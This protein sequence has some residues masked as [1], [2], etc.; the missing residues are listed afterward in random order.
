[1][2]QITL[3]NLKLFFRDKMTVFF[4]LLGVLIIIG[5]YV[6][7]LGDTIT[8]GMQDIPNARF[9]MDSWIMAGVLAVTSITTTMGAF[10]IMVDDRH[11]KLIKDFSASP[12]SRAS[13]AGGY[14]LSAYIIGVLISII[15]L[16]LFQFYVVSQG[17]HFL[18]PLVLIKVLG[19]VLL[20][21]LASSSMMFF[22]TSLIKS[23]NAFG[24]ASTVI[25]TLIGFMTGIYIP[26]GQLPE[27]VQN[28]IKFFPV[29]HAAVLFRKVILEQPL[30]DSF[31]GAPA[32]T[33]DSFAQFMGESFKY[34]DYVLPAIGSVIV[35]VGTSL[36]FY[37][38]SIWVVSRK[39]R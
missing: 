27:A 19:L 16:V 36:L 17:G 6:L 5:L 12:V 15:T 18:E 39:S 25:G 3:R 37:A 29:S 24:T 38:L 35:L 11:N 22:L 30:A 33:A 31:A 1:M 28:I 2:I 32:K 23:Q 21:V 34:G 26:I 8:S 7:F 20:S 10:G 13:L 14:I 9:L 4:S